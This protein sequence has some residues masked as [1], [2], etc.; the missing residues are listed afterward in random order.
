[1]FRKSFVFTLIIV[2]ILAVGVYGATAQEPQ[3]AGNSGCAA[4]SDYDPNCDVNRDG[5]M[6]VEDLSLVANHWGQAGVW[7]ADGD[8][9][10][11]GGNANI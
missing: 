7:T 10:Q 5:D 2:S 6:T 9:W 4:G 3:L 8:F 11:L 1:M